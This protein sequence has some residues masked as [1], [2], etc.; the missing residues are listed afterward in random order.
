MEESW[1]EIKGFSRYLIS[2]QGRLFNKKSDAIMSPSI[3]NH[4]HLKISLIRDDS[5]RQTRSVAIL[6]ASAF[7]PRPDPR[8]N[9]VIIKD[10]IL[11]NVAAYNLAW[12][13][14]WFVW[15]YTRQLKQVPPIYYMNLPI[16]SVRSNKLYSSVVT[17]SIEEGLLYRDVWVSMYTKKPVYPTRDIFRVMVESIGSV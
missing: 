12:R 9:G 13:P 1:Q 7:L 6:V 16:R 11:T 3:T 17:A 2:D 8:C 4:G 5:A 15:K 10:G 14:N